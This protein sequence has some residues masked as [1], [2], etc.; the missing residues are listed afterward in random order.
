MIAT[1]SILARDPETGQLG[2]AVQSKFLA[3]GSAVLWGRAGAGIVAT[4][5]HANLDIGELALPILAKGYPAEAVGRAMLALDPD[6]AIRQFGIV[7]ARG[8]SFSFTGDDCFDYAGGISRPNLAVQ[9]N[10]L[11]SRQTIVA[12]AEAFETARGSLARRLLS[13]LAA[14][15][16]A[17]G[18][19]RGR[20][21][22]ALLVLEA[23]GSYGG[24]NDR[25]IDLRVDDDPEP[26][27]RLGQLLDTHELLFHKSLPEQQL[28][29][30]PG[31]VQL[32]QDKL[33]RL[34]YY[35]GSLSGRYDQATR[36]ALSDFCG[37]ENLE[38]KM[39]AGQRIDQQVYQILMEK[40]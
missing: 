26:I 15:Q 2:G 18:D 36:Q 21:S 9:G 38:Q 22:A 35:Q 25:L 32:I 1:F 20:Q 5:A 30:T 10:I 34:G 19:K 6:S 37:W 17:G 14:G 16:A 33:R 31:L 12:L 24:Y 8:H 23:G 7:D 3:V 13:A 28:E 40:E 29:L 4:Q 11:V 27:E 39:V